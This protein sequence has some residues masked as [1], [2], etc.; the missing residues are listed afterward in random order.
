MGDYLYPYV[1]LDPPALT[2]RGIYPQTATLFRNSPRHIRAQDRSLRVG[3]LH[4]FRSTV[5]MNVENQRL[6][7]S[8]LVYDQDAAL[9]VFENPGMNIS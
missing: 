2:V 6:L 9:S 8:R 4:P 1:F 3:N 5:V 7:Q